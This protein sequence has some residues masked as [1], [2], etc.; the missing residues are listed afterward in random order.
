MI[1]MQFRVSDAE[2]KAIRQA[3][4]TEGLSVSEYVRRIVLEAREAQESAD[5]SARLAEVSAWQR[6]N[7]SILRRMY[8]VQNP[9]AASE[10]DAMI[11]RAGIRI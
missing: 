8:S 9:E 4:E 1:K 7:V 2:E 10:I 11:Q 5:I 6:V 3:A